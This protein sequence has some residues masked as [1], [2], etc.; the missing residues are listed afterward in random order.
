MISRTFNSGRKAYPFQTRL[1]NMADMKRN[2]I[3]RGFPVL[4]RI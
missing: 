1:N 3:F 4:F 2:R